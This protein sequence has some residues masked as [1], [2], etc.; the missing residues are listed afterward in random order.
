MCVCPSHENLV[1][2]EAS[3]D[4]RAS[5]TGVK[6]ACELS[7]MDWRS[8]AGPLEEQPAIYILTRRTEGCWAVHSLLSAWL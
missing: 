8:S 6:V 4:V 1:S 5:G 7:G 3:N 2:T